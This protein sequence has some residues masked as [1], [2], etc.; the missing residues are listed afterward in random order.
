VNLSLFHLG[1]PEYLLFILVPV[2]LFFLAKR[3][4]S[5]LRHA[6]TTLFSG[7]ALEK[8]FKSKP[9]SNRQ[10]AVI[11]LAFILFTAALVRPQYGFRELMEQREGLDIVFVIDV[12]RSMLAKDLSPNRLGRVR[13]A[14]T[15]LLPKLRG[16]RL[17]LI[18]FSGM[19]FV[20]SPLTY[21]QATFR[22]FL[23]DLS[24]DLV[25]L[26]GTNIEA[27]LEKV[28]SL[29]DKKSQQTSAG[30]GRN[31][32]LFTDGEETVGD[33]SK[34]SARLKEA[35]VRVYPV[36]IGSELGAPIPT[37]RGYTKDRRGQVV[38]SKLDSAP[39]KK[40]AADTGGAYLEGRVRSEELEQFVIS[41]ISNQKERT[42]VQGG[43]LRVWNEYYQIPLLLGM[44][45]YLFHFRRSA[46][47]AIMAFF[48]LTCP[49]LV[50]AAPLDEARKAFSEGNFRRALDRYEQAEGEGSSVEAQ[51]GRANSLY[52]LERFDEAKKIFEALLSDSSASSPEILYNLGNSKTQ[53]GQYEEAIKSYEEALKSRPDDIEI[54]ENLEYVK[55]LLKQ[56]SNSESSQSSEQSSEQASEQASERSSEQSDKNSS[57]SEG[58]EG[59]GDDQSSNSSSHSAQGGK[60]GDS[61]SLGSSDNSE[62]SS[63]RKNSSQSSASSESS[64]SEASEPKLG[65]QGG[66]NTSS[67]GSSATPESENE[68]GDEREE[69]LYD[70]VEEDRSALRK[71]R[72]QMALE[73]LQR[74]GRD[75]PERDW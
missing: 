75:I 37:E 50:Q 65:D 14:V 41:E 53:L 25:P 12:S 42:T 17:A 72:E 4:E 7:E 51:L 26:P 18:S 60:G 1:E 11:L 64:K 3:A 45:L 5:A 13:F 49:Q 29:Y 57:S 34:V 2:L 24:P 43:I 19:A 23:D 31:V 16:D 54:Q 8:L 52:R 71:Y 6:R 36:G 30:R 22:L 27:A 68:R 21:D 28:L 58:R 40:L 44:L 73:E 32:I 69:M 67:Q 70:A 55:K 48:F 38:L 74:T 63:E 10:P 61:S 39:L 56:Q 59:Q 20:E 62:Q 35:G 15:D 66:E 47:A 33:L 46:L 9:N